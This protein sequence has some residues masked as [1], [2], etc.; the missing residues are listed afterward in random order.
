MR[1]IIISVVFLLSASFCFGEWQI[2]STVGMSSYT[3]VSGND[4]DVY[5]GYS[6]GISSRIKIVDNFGIGIHYNYIY[7]PKI[8][9][10][11]DDGGMVIKNG[12]MVVEDENMVMKSNDC[13]LF[14]FDFLLGPSFLLYNSDRFRVPITVGL[15]GFGLF[16][17]A[18]NIDVPDNYPFETK[19]EFAYFYAGYGVGFSIGFEYHFN[20]RFYITGRIQGALNFLYFEASATEKKTSYGG[21]SYTEK[22]DDHDCGFNKMFSINPSIGVGLRF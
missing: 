3:A 5:D 17:Y 13:V 8:S 20:R 2:E 7:F 6:F 9:S 1:K 4:F 19:A 16:L 11:G 10:V 21:W 15:N 12:S 14:G 18:N 22:S